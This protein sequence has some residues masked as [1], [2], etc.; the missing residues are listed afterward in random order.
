MKFEA[1]FRSHLFVG[2][3]L[4]RCFEDN[5]L[6]YLVVGALFF[7][8]WNTIF[9][10]VQQRGCVFSGAKRAYFLFQNKNPSFCLNKS[11]GFQKK[12]VPGL[13]R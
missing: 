7:N 6:S 12:S 1:R 9:H 8:A 5:F 4:K 10:R 3:F 2:M 13:G 11:L